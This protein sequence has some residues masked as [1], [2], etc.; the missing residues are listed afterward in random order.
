[1]EARVRHQEAGE[2]VEAARDVLPQRLQLLVL[3]FVHLVTEN[4]D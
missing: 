2:L 1:M 3:T 4:T